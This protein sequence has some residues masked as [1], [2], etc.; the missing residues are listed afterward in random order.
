MNIYVIVVYLGA[1]GYLSGKHEDDSRRL[2][3]LAAP[4]AIDR[5]VAYTKEMS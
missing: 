2:I 5:L 3:D 1:G 4:P